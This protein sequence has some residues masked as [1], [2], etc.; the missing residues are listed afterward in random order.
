MVNDKD[1]FKTK[2]VL[3]LNDRLTQSFYLSCSVDS[4]SH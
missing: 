1:E 4:N 3:M 2:L